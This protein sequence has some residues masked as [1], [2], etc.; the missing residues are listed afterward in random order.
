M[1]SGCTN[2]TQIAISTATNY[3]DTGL[4]ENTTYRYRV[5]AYDNDSNNSGYSNTASAT[6]PG[7][8]PTVPGNLTATPSSPSKIGLSWSASTDSG[9][10][11][12][13]G[14]KIERCMG[15]GCSDFTQ[16]G[17]STATNYTDTGLN[18]DTTY[19]YQVR[20]YDNAGNNSGYSNTDSA[21]TPPE[22]TPPTIP[23]NLTGYTASGEVHLSWGASTDEGGSGLAGY[24][25][26]RCMGSGCTDFAEIGTSTAT[27]YTDSGLIQEREYNYRVRAY[28]NAGNSSGYSNTLSLYL[29]DSIPPTAPSNLYAIWT[30]ADQVDLSWTASTDSGGSGLGGYWIERCEGSGCTDFTQIWGTQ[31]LNTTYTDTGLSATTYNYRVAAFDNAGNVSGYSNTASVTLIAQ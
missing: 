13:A 20:A 9:G 10:S 18:G 4:S 15:S 19:S 16:I 22:I 6:T 31:N 21:T 29:P 24:K 7:I 8:P 14:Y 23:G 27:N 1:G 5:R 12:L 17:T 2:F 25:I 28:D 3:A 11:N 30:T 26:E